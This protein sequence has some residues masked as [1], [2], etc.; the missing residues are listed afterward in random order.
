MVNE[1]K[2]LHFKNAKTYFQKKEHII[3]ANGK[4]INCAQL[5]LPFI[6]RFLVWFNFV[7]A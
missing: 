2:M 6:L 3:C 7:S 1:Q 5:C 4:K